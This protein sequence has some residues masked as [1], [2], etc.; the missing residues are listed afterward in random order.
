MAG[1]K[2]PELNAFFHREITYFIIFLCSIFHCHVRLPEGTLTII[3]MKWLLVKA[4]GETR[5]DEQKKTS[6]PLEDLVFFHDL[7]EWGDDHINVVRLGNLTNRQQTWR[8]TFQ[9]GQTWYI[10][11]CQTMSYTG[12]TLPN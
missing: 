8:Y 5:K 6:F 7:H 1:W 12:Y 4:V 3:T 10:W 2:I 11:D 9:G